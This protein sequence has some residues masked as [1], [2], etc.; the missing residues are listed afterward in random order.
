MK[1]FL[2]FFL[3]VTA[4]VSEEVQ[5]PPSKRK[6]KPLIIHSNEFLKPGLKL[7]VYG[8]SFTQN[9]K[10]NVIHTDFFALFLNRNNFILALD[11][12]SILNYDNSSFINQPTKQISPLV[13]T[14]ISYTLPSSNFTIELSMRGTSFERDFQMGSS[15][16]VQSGNYNYSW[17][18]TQTSFIINET[19]NKY[20]MVRPLLGFRTMKSI[21]SR[22]VPTTVPDSNYQL[23]KLDQISNS[24]AHQSGVIFLLKPFDWLHI[25]LTSK[26]FFPFRGYLESNY[27]VYSYSNDRWNYETFRYHYKFNKL[28]GYEQDINFSFLFSS[29]E[30][31]VGGNY[32]VFQSSPNDSNRYPLYYN[33]NN[34]TV[35]P[36]IT[37]FLINKTQTD[38]LNRQKRDNTIRN[39]YIGL[40]Y[41]F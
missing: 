13:K 24:V 33:S 40:S 16:R 41:F 30:F 27:S 29:F 3:F 2:L 18:E 8:G 14:A 9:N 39:F 19:V 7:S 25:N 17:G 23:S 21:Y 35:I 36:N 20:F 5:S 6:L 10:T 11:Q 15:Q 34:E 4:I 31:T 26:I 1:S 12:Y 22:N 32:T 37:S 38:L 28:N